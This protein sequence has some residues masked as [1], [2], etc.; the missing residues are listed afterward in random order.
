MSFSN[1]NLAIPSVQWIGVFPSEINKLKLLSSQL[2]KEDINRMGHMIKR[3]YVS[4]DVLKE[5][6][7][8]QK[9]SKKSEVEA[10]M[11]DEIVVYLLNKIETGDMI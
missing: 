10:L 3:Q 5:L 2:T 7:I 11:S 1:D 4:R 8:L 9:I 6:L